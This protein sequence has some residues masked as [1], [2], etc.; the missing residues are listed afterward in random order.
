[1][2]RQHLLFEEAAVPSGKAFRLQLLKWI[3]NKQRF[4]HEIVSYFP[5]NHKGYYEPFLGSGAVLGTLSPKHGFASDA[6]DPLMEI[7]TQ[8][9]E[10]P[11]KV[12]R[13]Y[14]ERW[15]TIE[16]FGKDEAYERVKGS[17]NA[18][19]NGADLLFCAALVMGV[20]YGSGRP[21]VICPPPAASM[22]P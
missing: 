20:W 8:L 7:W 18:Q 16:L 17:Y 11:E 1:M 19:P 6:F 2:E 5:A 13:W 12:K 14:S 9:K 22:I 21:T 15:Q 10:S 3:G 4:A